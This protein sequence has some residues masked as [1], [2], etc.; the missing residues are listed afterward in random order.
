MKHILLSQHTVGGCVSTRFDNPSPTA[1]LVLRLGSAQ[2][3]VFGG[4]ISYEDGGFFLTITD[5]PNQPLKMWLSSDNIGLLQTGGQW[6]IYLPKYQNEDF[7]SVEF[8]AKQKN[9]P[10]VLP[11][12]LIKI[13]G[14]RYR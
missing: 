9:A 4:K 13:P 5:E 11:G 6:N 10:R 1:F 2:R 14:Y 8:W 7:V 12:S 3:K